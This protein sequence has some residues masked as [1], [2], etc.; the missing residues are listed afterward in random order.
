M[1]VDIAGLGN[2]DLD[3]GLSFQ[4]DAI[5]NSAQFPVLAANLKGCEALRNVCHPAAILVVKGIRIG[6]IGLVTRAETHLDPLECQIVDPIPVTKNL[7]AALR[8]LCDVVIL[9]SHLG[10]SMESPV[11]MADAG[12]VEVA[13]SLPYGCVDLIV[14]GHSHTVL[15]PNGL[16]AKNIV[17]GIPIVQAGASGK[18]L[19]QVAIEVRPDSAKV[20]SASLIPTDSLP[21]SP[22]FEKEMQAFVERARELW[23]QP[24]GRVDDI[25]DLNT[26]IIL[27]D[28]AKRE[29]VLANFVTDA[30]VNR[31]TQRGFQIDCAMIDA[32]ALQCGLPVSDHLKYGDCFEIMP[33]A[34]TLRLYQITGSQFQ[35]LLADNAVRVD[36][37][38]EPDLER[39]FLQFSREVRYSIALKKERSAAQALEITLHGSPL[40]TQLEKIFTIVSTSFIRN[41]AITW[42]T[43]WHSSSAYPLL[44][45]NTFPFKE[46][47]FLLRQELVAYIREN[48]GVTRSCGAQQDGRLTITYNSAIR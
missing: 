18:Y 27:N 17:N 28:F 36:H 19:G 4:A 24:M 38:N 3:R 13:S 47:D 33:Y 10:Y 45:I 5:Q 6:L 30:L 34:D 1:G 12:D 22:I 21:I 44:D 26:Q 7:V 25:P 20:T 43:K 40:A 48:G 31:L 39:G 15:N 29:M 42:E 9:I 32:S 23:K 41:S 46:T 37:L 35:E 11:P 14:G 16:V 8:P 2:H